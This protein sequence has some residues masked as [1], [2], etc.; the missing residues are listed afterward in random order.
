MTEPK[1]RGCLGCSFPILILIII[2]VLAIVIF[3]FL[4]GALTWLPAAEYAGRRLVYVGTGGG[5]VAGKVYASQNGAGTR[6]VVDVAGH[7]LPY[8]PRATLTAA[9]GYGYR[10]TFDVRLEAVRVGGQYAD[11]LNSAAT[12]ADGQQGLLPAHTLWNAAATWAFL[13]HTS[14]FISLTNLFDARYVADR[15]RGLLPGAPRT[16]QLGMS[17]GF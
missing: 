14:A 12:I 8:A 16:V 7:R 13:R 17:Q 9:A 1:K 4:S 2:I 6:Q 15:T 10:A 11:A 3:G 5:D